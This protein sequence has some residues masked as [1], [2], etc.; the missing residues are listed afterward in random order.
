VTVPRVFSD[1]HVFSPVMALSSSSSGR[2]AALS[3][4]L[5]IFLAVG[6]LSR[7]CYVD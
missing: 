5:S 3:L 7:S 1:F 2:S 4:V 6:S